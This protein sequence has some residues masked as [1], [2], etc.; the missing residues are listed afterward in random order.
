MYL[1]TMLNV[2]FTLNYKETIT[3][4][5]KEYIGYNQKTTIQI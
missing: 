5:Q 4:D 2:N 1:K 3:Y